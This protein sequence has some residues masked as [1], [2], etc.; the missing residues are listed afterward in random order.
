MTRFPATICE[1][2]GKTYGHKVSV[3]ESCLGDEFH[4]EHISGKGEVYAKTTIRTPAEEF[5]DEA[6]FNVYVIKLAEGIKI[7]GRVTSEKTV[8]TEDAVMFSHV[9]DD[10]CYFTVES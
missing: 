9:D 4:T 3:C 10:V 6:P 1:S 2:C 5:T 7:T 8:A